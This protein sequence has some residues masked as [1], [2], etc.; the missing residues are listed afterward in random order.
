MSSKKKSR[1]RLQQ[2]LMWPAF[3]AAAVA[4][5]NLIMFFAYGKAGWIMLPLTAAGVVAA[6][7]LHWYQKT[8]IYSDVLDLTADNAQVQHQVLTQLPVPYGLMDETG[9][10][11]WGND[12]LW[13]LFELSSKHRNYL[14]DI[15]AEI[16]KKDFPLTEESYRFS[17][18]MDGG[19]YRLELERL[20]VTE[21]MMSLDMLGIRDTQGGL[22]GVYLYDETEIVLYRRENDEEKMVVGLIYL[23]NYDE[24]LE[25]IEEVR[26]S[27]LAALID[28]KITRYLTRM[29]GLVKKIEKD[30]Y[31]VILKKK[32]I[33]AL[34]EDKFAL[35]EDVKTVS[36]GND[37][38]VTVSIGLGLGA[39]SY[40]KNYDHARTAMDMALGR[41]GDQAVV[42]DNDSI[43]YFGGKSEKMERNTRVKARVKAHA[44]R[45]LIEKSEK[46]LV[47]GHRIGDVDSYGA[48]VG[49]HRICM[50][51]GKK[52]HVVSG[53]V[54]TSVRPFLERVQNHME[55]EEPLLI[56]CEKALEVVD[57]STLVIVVDVNRPSFTECPGI[58]N[59]GCD[60]VVLDHHRQMAE[61]VDNAVLS[62]VEPYAS[63]TCELVAEILQY[64]G[65]EVR[66]SSSEADLMYSGIVV[67]TNNFINK[68]GVRTFEA[69][70][71]LRRNGADVTRVRK[72]LRD[73]MDDYK[74]RAATVSAAEIFG[75][76]YAISVCPS[77][78]LANPTIVG[79]Q[80]ANELLNMV[81]VKASF[82]LT[83]YNSE[84]YVSARSIDE[85]N[86]QIIMERFGGGGHMTASGT[87]LKDC[88]VEDAKELIKQTVIKM[89]EE[90]DI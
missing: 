79:A 40:T 12:R 87:Q 15:F 63:S 10:V 49:I 21:E 68:A 30:K 90:G 83:P 55:G 2:Y 57:T 18:Q 11:L 47:M 14:W 66:I 56:S 73:N 51:L 9:H 22:Y 17:A 20:P 31:L 67:D 48:A 74:A 50:S 24:V 71:Y 7:L 5:V 43:L 86:V 60:V 26:R 38:T 64:V 3:F 19:F 34:K 53:V 77:E 45:E 54:T 37:K 78:G 13:Q 27:L 8:R 76:A 72:M 32:Y 35:L 84:I 70:A 80:A 36:I 33:A 88:S 46:V 62:Y 28:R 44:L 4:V 89:A 65:G 69:A 58:L 81:G 6:G 29:D 52:C 1:G 82:V 85:V 75:Q 23:D 42:K 39:D 16:K 25:S 61:K 59:R 41:G